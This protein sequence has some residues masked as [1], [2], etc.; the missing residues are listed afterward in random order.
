MRPECCNEALDIGPGSRIDEV[1]VLGE[2]CR[3]V[4]GGGETADDDE[5]DACFAEC[6]N[7]CLE[8]GQEGLRRDFPARRAS[9]A[10]CCRAIRFSTRSVTVRRRFCRRSV[11]SMWRL[12]ASTTGSDTGA[13]ASPMCPAWRSCMERLLASRMAG[14]GQ[15]TPD[16]VRRIGSEHRT[17]PCRVARPEGADCAGGAG[18]KRDPYR[19]P[20]RR[21]M[22][23]P[24]KRAPPRIEHP[25]TGALSA[26]SLDL[27]NPSSASRHSSVPAT[28]TS[29]SA[30][31]FRSTHRRLMRSSLVWTSRS[32]PAGTNTET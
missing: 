7:D 30:S 20:A 9:A 28:S 11:R 13:R 15:S 26:K 21:P 16:V 31:R 19:Q 2:S 12:Y 18:R 17:A 6:S 29:S 1:D 24:L 14:S 4:N 22:L 27:P 10:R 8:V 25:K 23:R 5:L 3:P 32:M